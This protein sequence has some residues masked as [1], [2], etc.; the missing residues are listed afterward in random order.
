MKNTKG[1]INL[2]SLWSTI[3]CKR[4]R[5]FMAHDSDKSVAKLDVI[6]KWATVST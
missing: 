4:G 6:Y 2:S 5:N 1:K 3:Y